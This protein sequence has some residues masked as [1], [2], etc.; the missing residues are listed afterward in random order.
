MLGYEAEYSSEN[1]DD[2][3]LE[4]AAS[5]KT[6]L[7]TRDVELY[8]RAKAR[9]LEAFFVEGNNES[10]RLANI[11]T[12]FNLR[13]EIKTVVS[14]CPKCNSPLEKADTNRLREK[15]PRGTLTRYSEFW[16]CTGCGKIYWRGGHWKRINETLRKAR[17]LQKNKSHEIPQ[18]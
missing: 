1:L 2:R 3:L 12:R 8:R 6:V 17:D 4:L 13:L 16:K 5:G 15:I 9:N 7:L 10:E 11:A 18:D 14:R